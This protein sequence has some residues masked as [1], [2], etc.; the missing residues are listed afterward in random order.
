M[1]PAVNKGSM[2]DK[3]EEKH[4]FITLQM[5]GYHFS[6]KISSIDSETAL[7]H[8]QSITDCAVEEGYKSW[9]ENKG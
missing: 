9:E 6:P 3:R 4:S 2:P 5:N 8:H 1:L 7:G